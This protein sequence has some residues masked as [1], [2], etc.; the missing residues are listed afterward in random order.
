MKVINIWWVIV[1]SILI[2]NILIK[3]RIFYLLIIG[4]LNIMILP[5]LPLIISPK[6]LPLTFV[7]VLYFLSSF[8]VVLLSLIFLSIRNPSLLHFN[9]CFSG[10]LIRAHLTCF[11]YPQCWGDFQVCILC[12]NISLLSFPLFPCSGSVPVSLIHGCFFFS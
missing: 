7:T 1:L 5:L 8:S 9:F 3:N 6:L 10:P 2:S 12:L 4:Y 11:T